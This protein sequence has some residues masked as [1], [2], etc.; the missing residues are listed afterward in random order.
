M[1]RRA[2]LILT[3]CVAGAAQ[4][5]PA[6]R[7]FVAWNGPYFKVRHAQSDDSSYSDHLV[8][9]PLPLHS[10]PFAS[11]NALAVWPGASSP[12]LFVADAGHRR[13]QL[14]SA[15]A[16]WRS[17]SLSYSANPQRGEYGGRMIRPGAVSWLP[18]SELVL[19]RGQP[20][21]R[22]ASLAGLGLSDSVYMMESDGTLRLPAGWDL[23][24]HDSIAVEYGFAVPPGIAGMGDVDY[25]LAET[26]PS[27]LPL[28]LHDG[29]ADDDPDMDSLCALTVN[30]S[31][32]TDAALDLYLLNTGASGSLAGY[33]LSHVGL[34]GAFHF[35]DA[36]PFPL[37]HPMDVEI[38]DRGANLAGSVSVG[39]TDGVSAARLT[40]A[41]NNPALWTGHDYRITYAFDTTSAMHLPGAAGMVEADVAYDPHSGRLHLALCRDASSAR[42]A[43]SFSDDAGQSW[44]SPVAISSPSQTGTHSCPRIAVRATGEIHVVYEVTFGTGERR[45]F[46]TFSTDGETWSDAEDAAAELPAPTVLEHRQPVLLVDPTSD[47]VQL[48]WSA[49]DTF[50]HRI[51]TSA[52]G[53]ID[54]I[55][56]GNGEGLRAPAAAFDATGRIHLVFSLGNSAPYR[57]GHLL[58][59]GTAWGSYSGNEF[60]AGLI[61]TVCRAAGFADA[62]AGRGAAYPQPQIVLV[63]DALA[64][65]WAGSGTENYGT[66][67]AEL[68]ANWITSATGDFSPAAISA[69]T[70]GDDAAP[71]AFSASA[72]DAHSIHLVYPFGT[73]ANREGLRY[74][75]WSAATWSPPVTE[76]GRELLRA[77][78]ETETWALTP[79]LL[80]PTLGGRTIPL[81]ACTK[82]YAAWNGEP[83]VLLKAVDGTLTITDETAHATFQQSYV[84]THGEADS[85]AIPGLTLAISNGAPHISNTDDANAVEFNVGDSFTLDGALPVW[86]DRLFVSERDSNRVRV[87]R[88]GDNANGSFGGGVLLGNAGPLRRL[89][90]AELSAGRH[91][92]RS[93]LSR[94][95]RSGFRGVGD[96]R[97][98]ERREWNRPRL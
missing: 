24:G 98:S 80:T 41:V 4:A 75:R 87:I 46:H 43:Y 34:G 84:W 33:T 61:D 36:Y 57:V 94:M 66:D 50:L 14:F 45:L 10:T 9:S 37:A 56:V 19:L 71:L 58:D 18:Q 82:S 59:D 83:R 60:Q 17:E 85:G 74:K 12:A 28:Q 27:P 88:A 89:A 68:Y 72:D 69:I 73:A 5:A 16:N 23:G 91:W 42:A 31:A 40:V 30:T 3:L 81:L 53:E 92:R 86:N 95:G 35:V 47:A 63:G 96:C 90:R 8:S 2:L 64:V 78:T 6:Y 70:T 21:K 15:G 51:F 55:S 29:S 20:L 32:R 49:D 97:T 52:W 39:G 1:T 26:T 65:F 62:D 79:R 77:G 7:A 67:H 11:P 38:V 22:V 93:Q 54:T 44:S 76:A 48:L 13:V 25:V